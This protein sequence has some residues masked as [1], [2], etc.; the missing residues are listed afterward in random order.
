MGRQVREWMCFHHGEI[1]CAHAL[2]PLDSI[3]CA[4]IYQR[5]ISKKYTSALS[6][7]MRYSVD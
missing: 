7:N 1:E 2:W 4:Y 6:N 5:K 3:K